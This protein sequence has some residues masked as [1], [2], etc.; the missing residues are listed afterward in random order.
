MQEQRRI[1]SQRTYQ[2]LCR[3]T[4]SVST[5]SPI[6]GCDREDGCEG[7]QDSVCYGR[8]SGICPTR[9]LLIP[10]PDGVRTLP[11]QILVLP[12]GPRP[13]A[14][15]REGALATHVEVTEGKHS[16]E[17]GQRLG[18]YSQ[19]FQGG[20]LVLCCGWRPG[21]GVGAETQAEMDRLSGQY[22]HVADDKLLWIKIKPLS[23]TFSCMLQE[24]REIR[25]MKITFK[26]LVL[27][28]E[29]GQGNNH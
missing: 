4:E 10:D 8:G 22:T 17:K 20:R 19:S 7:A 24:K 16:Q 5:G 6:E 26:V 15:R 1:V 29:L 28:L 25:I 13:P 11:A 23:Q 18:F 21:G 3:V 14:P 27:T 9:Q 12:A 2:Q